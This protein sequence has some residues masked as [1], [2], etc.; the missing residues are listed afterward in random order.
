MPY[1]TQFNA[2]RM[3]GSFE[4]IDFVTGEIYDIPI[5]VFNKFE[6]KQ[7]S[8]ARALF[9]DREFL[10]GK[11][12]K[13][14]IPEDRH[15]Y[16][17]DGS[18]PRYHF[19]LECERLAQDFFNFEIPEE[20]KERGISEINR[21]RIWFKE[22]K[23]LLEKPDI[24][25][26]RIAA[27]FGL[28]NQI[29]HVNYDNSGSSEIENLDLCQVKDNINNLLGQIDSYYQT[30]NARKKYVIAKYKKLTYLAYKSD[31]LLD[32]DT[33]YSDT[34]VKNFLKVYD[35]T[36]KVPL[37]KLLIDYYRTLYNKDLKFLGNLLDALGFLP[38][39]TCYNNINNDKKL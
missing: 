20:I 13:T 24:F 5:Y 35:K 14:I 15:K 37:K 12:Y 27:A 17:F 33:G 31:P 18:K 1:I 10:D 39:L 6:L 7:L 21:F 29:K 8:A 34:A 9:E 2:L 23:D 25:N 16:V 36:F 38:C 30:A 28:K 4:E 19:N 26:M 11:M 32:N 3:L 22:N